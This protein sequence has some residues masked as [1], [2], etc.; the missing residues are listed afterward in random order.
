MLKV[1]EF[2]TNKTTISKGVSGILGGPMQNSKQGPNN[3]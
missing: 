1:I 2:E 3:H